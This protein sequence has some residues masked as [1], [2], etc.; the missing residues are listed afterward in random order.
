MITVA[1]QVLVEEEE[2]VYTEEEVEEIKPRSVRSQRKVPMNHFV[3]FGKRI[4]N[5]EATTKLMSLANVFIIS[6][7]AN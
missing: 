7:R 5:L 1:L 6:R 3:L 2:E 4:Q